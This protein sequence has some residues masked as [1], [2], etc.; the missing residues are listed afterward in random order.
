[1]A[2]VLKLPLGPEPR[3]AVLP[4]RPQLR[5][6]ASQPTPRRTRKMVARWVKTDMGLTAVWEPDTRR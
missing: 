6:I 1:M 5:L 3:P 2:T 4:R